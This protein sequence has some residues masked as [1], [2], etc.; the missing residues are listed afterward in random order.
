MLRNPLAEANRQWAIDAGLLMPVEFLLMH[1][2]AFAAFI[3][4]IE[5]VPARLAMSA[6]LILGYILLLHG[7]VGG[8]ILAAA[9]L[10]LFA[11][12]GGAALRGG[13]GMSDIGFAFLT[14]IVFIGVFTVMTGPGASG[15]PFAPGTVAA[16]KAQAGRVGWWIDQPHLPLRALMYWFAALGVI[17]L[18]R[19]FTA[20]SAPKTGR[21]GPDL[22]IG[23]THVE[24]RF[25]RDAMEVREVEGFGEM[26]LP[27]VM[28]GGIPLMMGTVAATGGAAWLA[29]ILIPAG[30][31]MCGKF[32]LSAG[33]VQRVR[34]RAGV[35]EWDERAPLWSGKRR[36]VDA[37]AASTLYIQIVESVND[38]AKGHA[39]RL[40]DGAGVLELAW[41]VPEQL[42]TDALRSLLL[43][44]IEHGDSGKVWQ[45]LQG[46][47]EVA[48]LLGGKGAALLGPRARSALPALAQR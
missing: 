28:L 4:L 7:F 5:S 12:I 38:V 11:R 19:G 9:L 30:I 3:A 43:A 24:L 22:V 39:L 21:G 18:L 32:L 1:A 26:V 42:Q 25:A 44:Y 47:K 8:W 20:P 29:W 45:A 34:A 16:L 17:E 36:Q 13:G 41:G 27:L 40:G 46:D 37:H 31:Y 2:G 48:R 35:L 23:G 15:Q 14:L 33:R 10:L 6:A